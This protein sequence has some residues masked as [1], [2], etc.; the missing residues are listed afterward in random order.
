[1]QLTT[2]CITTPVGLKSTDQ[3]NDY[4]PPSHQINTS[5]QRDKQL[6][7]GRHPL[8]VSLGIFKIFWRGDT[9]KIYAMNV[10]RQKEEISWNGRKSKCGYWSA[11]PI[12]RSIK[13]QG[14]VV[15]SQR[16]SISTSQMSNLSPIKLIPDLTK[17][18]QMASPSYYK[19]DFKSIKMKTFEWI[20]S[21]I[22][23]KLGATPMGCTFGAPNRFTIPW[24]QM[25]ISKA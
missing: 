5:G 12:N 6:S 7:R 20:A 4:T 25:L 2:F 19:N 13:V 18:G 9:H 17:H 15:S 10:P 14:G 24:S 21:K 16:L 22:H 1:M 11:S 23:S 8:G 3:A